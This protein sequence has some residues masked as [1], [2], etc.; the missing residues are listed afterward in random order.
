MVTIQEH[1]ILN[2]EAGCIAANVAQGKKVSGREQ[3][4][5]IV[6]FSTRCLMVTA[7]NHNFELRWQRRVVIGIPLWES[8]FDF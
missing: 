6:F 1:P 5:H 2:D 3:T 7:G 4:A 8:A